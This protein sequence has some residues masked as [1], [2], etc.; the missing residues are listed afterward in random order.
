MQV[1]EQRATCNRA[2]A[3]CNCTICQV[4][5]S[6]GCYL[7]VAITCI[8]CLMLG[9]LLVAA[10]GFRNEA[11]TYTSGCKSLFDGAI[12]IKQQAANPEICLSDTDPAPLSKTSPTEPD[13]DPA[14][15]S[16]TS[17]TEPDTVRAPMCKT[18]SG[19]DTD[20]DATASCVLHTWPKVRVCH[21]HGQVFQI[22][23][24]C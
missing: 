21:F 8:L 16:K 7:F 22:R 6:F 24:V 23:V 11:A 2:R 4:C 3:T 9:H 13:T 20:V 19:P 1:N 17:P 12:S 14:P 18:P 5:D 15:L 10:V